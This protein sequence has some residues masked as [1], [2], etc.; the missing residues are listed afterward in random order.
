MFCESTS[1]A[2]N[3]LSLLCV[4]NEQMFLAQVLSY[5]LQ[6]RDMHV[7]MPQGCAPHC[8]DDHIIILVCASMKKQIY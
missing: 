4:Y 5:Q 6:W 8:Q 3:L 1:L 7:T 2:V